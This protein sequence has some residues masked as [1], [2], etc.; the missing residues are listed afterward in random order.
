[1]KVNIYLI[2]LD[3][4][5]CKHNWTKRGS[6]SENIAS[7]NDLTHPFFH[8]LSADNAASLSSMIR[9]VFWEDW[10]KIED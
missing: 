8:L 2:F 6:N 10:L 1:M 5:Q 9:C 7:T 3:F 4:S